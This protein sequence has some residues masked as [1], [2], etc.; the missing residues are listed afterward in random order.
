MN[1]IPITSK[2]SA[3]GL[4][5]EAFQWETTNLTVS[6]SKIAI[7]GPEYYILFA[8]QCSKNPS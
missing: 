5:I 4:N 1:V 8:G 6:F 2:N 7:Q 3:S